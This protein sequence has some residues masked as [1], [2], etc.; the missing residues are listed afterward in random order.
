MAVSDEDL[1]LLSQDET[2]GIIRKMD[3]QLRAKDAEIER[4]QE[5]RNDERHEANH[6]FDV[7]SGKKK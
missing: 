7:L 6:Y 2:V 1:D 3:D 4:L 5:E